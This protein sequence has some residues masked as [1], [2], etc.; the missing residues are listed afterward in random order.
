MLRPINRSRCR[1]ESEGRNFQVNA[2]YLSNQESQELQAGRR[3]GTEDGGNAA[4]E[5][6][7]IAAVNQRSRR[8]STRH[9]RRMDALV[10]GYEQTN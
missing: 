6:E 2:G 5:D 9:G 1:G 3:S 8:L 7:R 4:R 10:G